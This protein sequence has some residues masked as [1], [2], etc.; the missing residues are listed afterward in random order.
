MHWIL[1]TI[2][3][4]DDSKILGFTINCI[5]FFPYVITKTEMGKTAGKLGLWKSH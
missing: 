4:E 5:V 2:E 1:G 3:R